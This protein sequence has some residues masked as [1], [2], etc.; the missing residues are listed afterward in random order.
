M[1]KAAE[2]RHYKRWRDI[3]FEKNL[4]NVNTAFTSSAFPYA[5]SH[6]V[7]VTRRPM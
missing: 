1:I 3:N 4:R 5:H 7:Y 6:T 2:I